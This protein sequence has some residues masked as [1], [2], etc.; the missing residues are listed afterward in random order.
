MSYYHLVADG[1]GSK[2][3]IE[4]SKMKSCPFCGGDNLETQTDGHHNSIVVHCNKCGSQGPSALFPTEAQTLWNSQIRETL[5]VMIPSELE[6]HLISN[7]NEYVDNY[8]EA[9]G[10]AFDLYKVLKDLV[11]QGHTN[12][13]VEGVLKKCEEYEPN[14]K[15]QE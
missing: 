11:K 15:G 5:R 10:I 13:A 9:K 12:P 1:D 6:I 14:W 4:I 2:R 7:A 3:S 8:W